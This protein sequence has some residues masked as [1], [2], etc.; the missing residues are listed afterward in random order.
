MR[1]TPYC[2][3][4]DLACV[5][6]PVDFYYKYQ[7]VPSIFPI[8]KTRQRELFG[9]PVKD[10]FPPIS[11]SIVQF[12]MALV[13]VRAPPGVVR[14][15]E[16]YFALIRLETSEPFII[17]TRP[18]PGPQEIELEILMEIQNTT[19][20]ESTVTKFTIFVDD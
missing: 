13:D 14:A 1:A 4:I 2:S 15:T 19:F 9:L 10:T 17:L 20:F 5:H 11:D 7:A 18:I 6:K 12:S 8:S 16:N 3:Q